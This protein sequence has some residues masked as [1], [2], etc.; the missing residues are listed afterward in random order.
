MFRHFS[1]YL[2]RLD[3]AYRD[4]PYFVG[5]KAR[6]L[7][8]FAFLLLVFVPFNVGKILWLGSPELMFR[9]AFNLTLG[10]AAVL[11]LLWVRRGRLELAGDVL[12]LVAVLPVHGLLF[13][14]PG[15]AE[16]LGVAVQILAFDFILLLFALVFASRR[17]AIGVLLLVVVTYVVFYRLALHAE[18]IAGS[19]RFA[20][21]TWLRDG[22]V[23]I[24]F[25]F[26]LGLTVVRMIEAAH[27]RSE[28]ALR[29][30]RA[31]NETL[32]QK[33]SERTHE[34]ETATLRA[35]DASR[36]KS[37]FLANMSHEI[38]TPLNGI[39]ASADLLRRRPDLPAE[40]AEHARLIADSGELLMKLLSDILD[41]S[42][43]EAGQVELE[44][45]HFELDALVRDNLALAAAQAEQGGVQLAG[46]VAPGLAR[47]FEGDSF[48]LRQILINLLSN[49][50]KF[51]P[52]GG[53]VELAVTCPDPAAVPA[54]VHFV[55]RDT[56]IGMDEA[57]Q[58]RL[59][60]RFTQAD[61]STTRRFG[62]TGLGLAIS[63][64]LVEKM[65]GRIEVESALGRGSEFRF[66]IP[67]R[68]V[69]PPAASPVSSGAV[70]PGL[71][72]SILVAED[73]AVNR[74][75]LAAQLD[76]LGC[77]HSMTVDGEDLLRALAEGPAPDVVLMDCH[78]PRLDGWAATRR[79]RGWAG[80]PAAPE[81][82]RRISAV[83]VIALTA[84]ALPEERQRCLDAGMND[85]LAKPV[86]LADLQRVLRP[87]ARVALTVG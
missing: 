64:R 10:S 62:G 48:R 57:T 55:V 51:T 85:F 28:Q 45:H 37:E 58:R 41:F 39:I 5:L 40:A 16:P 12:A 34:L 53:R 84:A 71:G 56:G 6:L 78:M 43:I 72:L 7:A 1:V 76:K 22:L 63:A 68:A 74:K 8:A 3:A 60:E 50:I 59:F 36:A 27:G 80:D 65:G 87:F 30:T 15:Y 61:T 70:F 82:Q 11:T 17:I 20:A 86:K 38:R 19:L 49:A 44:R 31:L 69:D 46:S 75:V 32:E 81:R 21:D 13:L 29:E 4:Q 35:N 47:A 67:L 66:T 52:V 54:S 77:R 33:V 23:A 79:L 26:A 73:N 14:A 42:K 18:P 24:G 2:D 9:L 83:P 25:V